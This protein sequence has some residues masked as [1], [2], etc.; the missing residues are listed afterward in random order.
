[1]LNYVPPCNENHPWD[2]SR[3]GLSP[4]A[5]KQLASF[6]V[7]VAEETAAAPPRSC[8]RSCDAGEKFAE[9]F[10]E[11]TAKQSLKILALEEQ[12]L[13]CAIARMHL[14]AW[15]D[16]TMNCIL[17]R[18]LEQVRA[19]FQ[20]VATTDE[21]GLAPGGGQIYKFRPTGTMTSHLERHQLGKRE[22]LWVFEE[23][24]RLEIQSLQVVAWGS[25]M[26]KKQKTKETC[27]K[28]AMALKISM[29]KNI[30]MMKLEIL[31][32]SRGKSP[33]E[34]TNWESQE[35][36]EGAETQDSQQEMEAQEGQKGEESQ[37]GQEGKE[38]Q[39]GQ[40][41]Y[42]LSVT[43][44]SPK[45]SL[46]LK[47]RRGVRCVPLN[48]PKFPKAKP[49]LTTRSP[50]CRFVGPIRGPIARSIWK[51]LKIVGPIGAPIVTS[52][53]RFLKKKSLEVQK[54]GRGQ[55]RQGEWDV[56]L[57]EDKFKEKSSV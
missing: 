34:D 19:Q 6:Q 29:E 1:M 40:D 2:G 53:L 16:I 50:R 7:M 22:M 37:D 25:I 26:E 17:T 9:S 35:I 11:R 21:V 18:P 15:K 45:L 39:K 52:I 55:G 47:S 24:G 51:I 20:V 46:R 23:L 5:L 42:N 43:T 56:R 33:N 10:A 54:F 14:G 13:R 27:K 38:D 57:I 44:K 28:F 30:E 4:P 41:D 3:V 36:R 49:R 8:R 12:R 32:I 31:E 48:C